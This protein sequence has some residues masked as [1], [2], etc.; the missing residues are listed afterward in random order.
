MSGAASKVR[1]SFRPEFIS[2]RLRTVIFASCSGEAFDQ[3]GA[4]VGG[5]RLRDVEQ[6]LVDGDA[7]ENGDEALLLR[8][9]VFEQ[10]PSAAVPWTKLVLEGCGVRGQGPER[11]LRDDAV[12]VDDR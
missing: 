12:V 10:R 8:G 5:D 11:L 2:S 1:F 4:D 7:D 3:P 9:D 6:A